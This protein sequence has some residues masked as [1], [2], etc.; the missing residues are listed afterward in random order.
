MYIISL[1][2]EVCKNSSLLRLRLEWENMFSIVV[3]SVSTM[4]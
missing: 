1:Q 4:A 3:K 2:N